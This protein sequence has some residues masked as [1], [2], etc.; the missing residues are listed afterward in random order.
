MAQRL[1]LSPYTAKTHVN[2]IMTKLEARDRAQLAVAYQ[3]GFTHSRNGH[4][5]A[6]PKPQSA[7]AL[8]TSPRSAAS[9]ISRHWPARTRAP[10]EIASGARGEGRQRTSADSCPAKKRT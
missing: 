1:H 6:S 4:V 5:C 9:V 8:P 2:R 10:A 3:T 7:D